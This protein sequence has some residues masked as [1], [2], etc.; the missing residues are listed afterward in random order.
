MTTRRNVHHAAE[1]EVRSG[2]IPP[3]ASR[4]LWVSLALRL[5]LRTSREAGLLRLAIAGG[6]PCGWDGLGWRTGFLDS[7]SNHD[8][9]GGT[10]RILCA[11]T[12]LPGLLPARCRRIALYTH[13]TYEYTYESGLVQASLFQARRCHQPRVVN[14]RSSEAEYTGTAVSMY[15][16]YSSK[17]TTVNLHVQHGQCSVSYM[18]FKRPPKNSY[19]FVHY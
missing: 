2:N 14:T 15:V 6:W 9:A 19:A 11:C 17:P 7:H 16:E 8:S 10:Y 3:F 12:T 4:K 5:C 1:R 13:H 18:L